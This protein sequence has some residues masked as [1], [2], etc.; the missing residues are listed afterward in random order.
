MRVF[1]DILEHGASSTGFAAI[2]GPASKEKHR[3]RALVPFPTSSQCFSGN[4][5]RDTHT[6]TRTRTHAARHSTA[7]HACSLAI[8]SSNDG[9]ETVVRA[10]SRKTV[11]HTERHTHAPKN[12]HIRTQ[13]RTA[14]THTHR[15]TNICTG[16]DT[17]THTHTHTVMIR[18]RCAAAVFF[19]VFAT[20]PSSAP[21]DR[22]NGSFRRRC[23]LLTSGAGD[24]PPTPAVISCQ[25]VFAVRFLTVPYHESYQGCWAHV[26]QRARED[27]GVVE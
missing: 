21:P 27:R 7:Q 17:H 18:F 12:T 13:G 4:S 19:A 24:L 8:L 23:Q 11:L 25:K 15:R 22:R 9:K 14:H 10:R 16:T 6:Q 5:H 1:D 26:S 2:L 20:A 3:T